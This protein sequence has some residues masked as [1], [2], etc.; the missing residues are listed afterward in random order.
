MKALRPSNVVKAATYLALG[1]S[2]LVPSSQAG[3]ARN[4]GTDGKA[5][6]LNARADA[7]CSVGGDVPN[8]PSGLI[9]TKVGN[10]TIETSGEQALS[11][12]GV[13]YVGNPPSVNSNCPTAVTVNGTEVCG[14]NSPYVPDVANYFLVTKGDPTTVAY[15]GG[16]N[17]QGV[18]GVCIRETPTDSFSCYLNT[19]GPINADNPCGSQTGGSSS[20]LPSGTTQGSA[21]TTVGPQ[22][23]ATGV[24]ATVTEWTTIVKPQVTAEATA[25]VY[26]PKKSSADRNASPPGAGVLRPLAKAATGLTRAAYAAVVGSQG[27]LQARSG[28]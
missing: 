6:R 14:T 25:T 26:S 9:S 23:T 10:I 11:E 20:S 21:S 12:N 1:A 22:G 3:A 4:E 18:G 15:V 17:S 8:L 7:G 27:A 19:N 28:R 24:P 13:I 16:V 2:A 5:V